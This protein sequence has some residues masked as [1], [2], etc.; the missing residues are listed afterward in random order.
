MK[1]SVGEEFVVNFR[2]VSS[3][4]ELTDDEKKY[5]RNYLQKIFIII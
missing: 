5:D 4:I 2:M 1:P 3:L